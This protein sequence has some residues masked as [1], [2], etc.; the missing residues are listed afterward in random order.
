MS[1]LATP[2]DCKPGICVIINNMKFD[3]NNLEDLD[4]SQDQYH[5]V[6]V[7]NKLG[8]AVDVYQNLTVNEMKVEVGKYGT[9][10]HK[11]V[12]ILIILSH[13]GAG[14]VVY[15][16]RYNKVEVHTLQEYFYACYKVSLSGWCTESVPH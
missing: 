8:F 3:T 12:F 5:L 14:D 9:I 7:F 6:K 1:P 13:G 11:G 4:G 15:G 2:Y 16:T 10:E